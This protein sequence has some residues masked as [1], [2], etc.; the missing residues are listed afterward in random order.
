MVQCIP[1]PSTL[2]FHQTFSTCSS[3]SFSNTVVVLDNQAKFLAPVGEVIISRAHAIVGTLVGP[4][5]H[6]TSEGRAGVVQLIVQLWLCFLFGRGL[7][8]T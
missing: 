7:V 8:I 4:S 3:I 6:N 5:H 1:I 2:I